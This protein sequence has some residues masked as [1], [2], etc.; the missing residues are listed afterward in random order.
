V[1]EFLSI[2]SNPSKWFG[3]EWNYA[4]RPTSEIRTF[5]QL[6]AHF[7]DA[8]F[9]LCAPAK[10]ITNPR[11]DQPSFELL[12]SKAD[13]QKAL[14]DSFVFCDDAFASLTDESGQ[15]LMTVGPQQVSRAAI[16]IRTLWHGREVYGIST[17]YLRLK[18][19]V[20][21]STETA[22]AARSRASA[23]VSR[24]DGRGQ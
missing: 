15:Q 21:P 19:Q 7:A 3:E 5:G 22:A 11:R 23:P 4:F 2:R 6:I 17:V 13:I 12:T 8:Q 20:P 14:A 18:G 9:E 16:L 24:G 10:G 1:P